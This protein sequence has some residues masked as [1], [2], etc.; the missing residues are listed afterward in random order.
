VTERTFLKGSICFTNDSR[1]EY[2]GTLST[3]CRSTAFSWARGNS[4][5]IQK[6]LQLYFDIGK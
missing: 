6:L 1:R 3:T 2:Y 4:K 5:N